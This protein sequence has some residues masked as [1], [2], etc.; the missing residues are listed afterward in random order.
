MGI[1]KYQLKTYKENTHINTPIK[2]IIIGVYYR[3]LKNIHTI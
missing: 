1:Y 3:C 2:N